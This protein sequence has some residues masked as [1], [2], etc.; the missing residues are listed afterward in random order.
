MIEVNDLKKTSEF[1]IFDAIAK[2]EHE[3]VVFC[4]DSETGLRAI[5]GFIIQFLA[6]PWRHKDVGI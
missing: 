6:R 2:N 1:E 5:L 3:Q 4:N